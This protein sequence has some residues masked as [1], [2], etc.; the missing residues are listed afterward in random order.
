MEQENPINPDEVGESAINLSETL[1]RVLKLNPY[2]DFNS[3]RKQDS[4]AS[5]PVNE[6]LINQSNYNIPYFSFGTIYLKEVFNFTCVFYT[7]KLG[8]SLCSCV[9][10]KKAVPVISAISN[11]NRFFQKNY[12]SMTA[13]GAFYPTWTIYYN[14]SMVKSFSST[15]AIMSC[16]YSVEKIETLHTQLK[17]ELQHQTSSRRGISILADAIL[18]SKNESEKKVDQNIQDQLAK[19]PA[20]LNNIDQSLLLDDEKIELSEQDF[21]KIKAIAKHRNFL[22]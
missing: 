5:F 19:R 11:T 6:L 14:N 16:P 7:L 2:F 15:I 13:L 9:Y 1:E 22:A 17:E 20:L 21:E 18:E 12:L 3:I 4:L 10:H 8:F